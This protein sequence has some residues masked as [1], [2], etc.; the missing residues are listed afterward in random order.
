M[1]KKI[2]ALCL[3]AVM[4][5][6]SLPLVFAQTALPESRHD[7][8]ND[9]YET[10]T[11]AVPGAK[12]LL[13]TFSEDT[14]VED[15]SV[16]LNVKLADTA[17]K[18]TVQNVISA[19]D[20]YKFGDRIYLYGAKDAYIGAYTGDALASQTVFIP[21]DSVKI[22]L[23]TDSS[24]TAYG[25]RVTD[26]SACPDSLMSE[27][28]YH[29][30]D[31]V[32]TELYY[33]AQESRLY[34]AGD[35]PNKLKQN[36]QASFAGWSTGDNDVIAFDGG[37]ILPEGTGDLEL[38]PVWASSLLAPEEVFTFNNS[39]SYFDE[40]DKGGY[41]LTKE[42][43]AM[44]E[45]NIFSVFGPGPVPAAILGTVLYTY[46]GWDWRGSCYGMSTVTFL[47][48]Y[49][50]IDVLSLQNAASMSEM[51]MTDELKSYINY[52]QAQAATSWLCENKAAI[53]GSPNYSACL[54]D[55]Y[56]T[57]ASGKIAMLT[58]YEGEAFIT[59]GH[60]V[61]AVGAYTNK[62]GE[63]ELIIYD[64]NRPWHYTSGMTDRFVISPD[65]SH[66][67]DCYGDEVGAVNWTDSY[68]QF[69]PFDINGGGN[70]LIWHQTF[71]KH[72]GEVF[73]RIMRMIRSLFGM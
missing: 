60:T 1:K 29:L 57:V 40:D 67:I 49:G 8:G 17:G 48:H 39:S 31:S 11:Y 34:D 55:L 23:S 43:M 38:Y 71:F 66:V 32:R 9:V 65:Y 50:I 25:F 30:D 53:P 33:L 69:E 15:S 16:P 73:E 64:N 22:V 6:T 2:L 21:G 46:P 41:Y 45:R 70:I 62:K 4:L 13:V 28:N 61:L 19:I 26:I 7:Y 72:L 68:T 24:V 12:A 52:Y 47:Q 35:L 63:H 20:A 14:F 36:R 27:V 37:E 42:G 51:E 54:R 18:V 5:L 44:L 56:D 3:S 59:S 58:F 10:Y